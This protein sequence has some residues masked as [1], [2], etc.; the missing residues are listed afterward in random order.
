MSDHTRAAEERR[1]R[2][3]QQQDDEKI[4]KGPWRHG[5]TTHSAMN[6][7]FPLVFVYCVVLSSVLS[8]AFSLRTCN[9]RQ[10]RE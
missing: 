10:L 2:K 1:D 6:L 9:V 8:A 5:S 7:F 3:E 4:Q